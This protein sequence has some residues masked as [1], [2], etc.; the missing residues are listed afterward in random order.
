M[1]PVKPENAKDPNDYIAQIDDERRRADI[2]ALDRLIREEAPELERHLAYGML[3]YGPVHYRYE[4]GREGDWSLIGLASQKR[5]I[6]L[7]ICA[8]DGDGYIAGRY[9]HRLPKANIGKGCVRFSRLERVD[10]EV[11]RELVR[12]AAA[13]FAKDPDAAFA[14]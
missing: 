7:Y 12:E 10:E 14:Q 11:L 2:E 1:S 8:A 5:Y 3:G 6:S 13:L 4:S 9:G